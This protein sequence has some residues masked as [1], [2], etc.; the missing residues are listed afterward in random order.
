M[1]KQLTI[2]W[3]YP[4]LM[5]TYGDRGNII[6]LQKRCEWRGIDVKILR[7]DFGF[8]IS[9]LKACDMLF[10]GGAQDTQQTIV[11]KD[12]KE[13][14]DVEF[15]NGIEK[16]NVEFK[17]FFSLMFGGGEGH[18]SVVTETKKKRGEEET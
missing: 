8:R 14:I 16:I 13:K 17:N 7:L 11:S 4:E 6:S 5:S 18:L 10:M 9:D 3:L 2:G 12:L 15:K 1:K